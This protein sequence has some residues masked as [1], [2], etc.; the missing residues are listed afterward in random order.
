MLLAV[1][2][3]PPSKGALGAAVSD[4]CATLGARV[5]S[6]CPEAAE[7]AALDA[8]VAAVGGRRGGST[9][10]PWTARVSSCKPSHRAGTATPRCGPAWTLPGTPRARSSTGRSY[11]S[12]RARPPGGSSTSRPRPT[13]A[14]TQRRGVRGTREPRAHA[15]DRV[16]APRDH[17]G[18]G[19]PR[20]ADAPRARWR[21]SRLPRLARGRLL[22]G[23]P[24]GPARAVR[25]EAGAFSA[26]GVAPPARCARS[27]RPAALSP[28]SPRTSRR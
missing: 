6:C 17:D 27:P 15:L 12:N 9:C 11:P 14:R 10:W 3:G 13:R 25:E 22:L 2:P 23:V 18:D 8:A 21:R 1:P 28:S 5:S 4:A 7:E 20:R 19:R 26:R 16:G 24:A